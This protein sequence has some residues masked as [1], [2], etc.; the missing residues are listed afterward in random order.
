MQGV[1]YYPLL[2]KTTASACYMRGRFKESLAMIKMQDNRVFA[3][4][5]DY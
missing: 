1:N 4:M 5:P 3:S 2:S